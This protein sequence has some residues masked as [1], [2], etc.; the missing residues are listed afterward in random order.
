MVKYFK[1]SK[2]DLVAAYNANIGQKEALFEKCQVI[3][4]S[5]G[6]VDPVFLGNPYTEYQC[7]GFRFDKTPDLDLWLQN[8]RFD[9]CY[10]RKTPKVK[11]KA[12]LFKELHQKTEAAFNCVYSITEILNEIIGIDNI[13]QVGVTVRRS[14]DH[15]TLYLEYK[16]AVPKVEGWLEI[17]GS[18]FESLGA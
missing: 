2:A 5:V 18:E 14:A 13:Y 15:K 6:A 11:K 4:K 12:A 8:K 1:T 7:R 9:Y 17:M 16:G 3:A 10:L